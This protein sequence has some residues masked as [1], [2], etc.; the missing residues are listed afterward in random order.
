MSLFF[1]SENDKLN[2]MI[3]TRYITK[4]LPA[5]PQK[6]L[7]TSFNC[8]NFRFQCILS[9]LSLVVVNRLGWQYG[10]VSIDFYFRPIK[11]H[12][13]LKYNIEMANFSDYAQCTAHTLLCTRNMYTHTYIYILSCACV[14]AFSHTRGAVDGKTPPVAAVFAS[15]RT[16]IRARVVI[17]DDW[18]TGRAN[19]TGKR[20]KKKSSTRLPLTASEK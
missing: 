16:H 1:H 6:C 12:T 3:C 11:Y 4:Y 5:F 15:P 17:A 20:K 8:I 7:N 18:P 9:T 2:F 19:K 14:L 10:V 13:N